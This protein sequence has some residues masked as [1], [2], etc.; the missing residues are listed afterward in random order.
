[1]AQGN[2]I[3]FCRFPL[4]LLQYKCRFQGS[5]LL[6][7]LRH[8]INWNFFIF[9][10]CVC[11]AF[12][13]EKY[14]KWRTVKDSDGQMWLAP[15]NHRWCAHGRRQIIYCKLII[16]W[17]MGIITIIQTDRSFRSKVAKSF[18]FHPVQPSFQKK[19]I[20]PSLSL[21]LSFSCTINWT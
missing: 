7:K 16:D 18:R 8:F 9:I 3:L 1:M 17:L 6:N 5:H 20:S 15:M 13:A 4:L 12:W 10:L 11:L 21:A 14:I 19:N 2:A